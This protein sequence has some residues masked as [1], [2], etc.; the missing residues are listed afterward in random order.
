LD[1]Y[2]I[3]TIL[4]QLPNMIDSAASGS[5]A[6][7]GSISSP[8]TSP[9]SSGSAP[10]AA[11]TKLVNARTAHIEVVLKLVATP[12]EMLVERFRIMWPEGLLQDLQA[13]MAL[14]DMKRGDQQRCLEAFG[15]NAAQAHS[16]GAATSPAN[17]SGTSASG[18]IT[19]VRSL[20]QDISSTAFSAFRY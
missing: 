20:T 8:V 18:L 13:V 16:I 1:T 7:T 17:S 2:N 5:G 3:K 4:L 11:F 19:S 15:L 9:L 6:G 12:E 14:R 10:P